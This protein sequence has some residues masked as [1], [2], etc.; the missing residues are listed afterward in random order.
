MQLLPIH[1]HN[2]RS[3]TE[4]M[5]A[6]WPECDFE[7]ELAHC[8]KMLQSDTMT[9]FLAQEGEEYLA[10]IQL[11]LRT[12]PVEGT[13]SSPVAYI[14][15]IY[16]QPAWRGQGVGRQLVER[17]AAW[18]REQGCTD[19]ASDVE[20]HNQESLA[21]HEKMGFREANRVVCFARKL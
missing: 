4:M 7:E 18:G 19:Y 21:F 12:D 10:F 9:C 20:W 8:Q 14:E 3:L 17:G 1:P 16:V 15:G 13:S 11:S 6:L 2:L 5:L